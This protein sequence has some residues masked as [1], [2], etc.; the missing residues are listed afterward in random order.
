[1]SS[2]APIVVIRVPERQ[3]G[4]QYADVTSAVRALVDDYGLRVIVDGSPNSIPPELL[5]TVREM[6]IAVEPMSREEIESIPE[7]DGFINLLKAHNLDDPVW[8]VLGGSPAAYQ[9]LEAVLKQKSSL[10]NIADDSIVNQ[11]KNHILSVL[12]AALNN[13]VAKSSA[14]TEAIIKIFREKKTIG[15]PV[16]E[17]KAMGFLLDYP[18]KVFREVKR[19]ERW[20]VEP[21]T[22]AVSLIISENVQSDDGVHELL[23]KL[24]KETNEKVK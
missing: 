15:I 5:S 24:F 23:E 12:S 18:N 7:F 19:S 13:N 4:Q 6:V 20:Y 21:S 22:P 16:M 11:V 10:S 14:N 8:K 1:M 2:L 3:I 9:V 17:L